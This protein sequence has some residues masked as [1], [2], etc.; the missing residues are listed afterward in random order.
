MQRLRLQPSDSSYGIPKQHHI[1]HIIHA[2]SINKGG[3]RVEHVPSDS[4]KRNPTIIDD[5]PTPVLC[6]HNANDNGDNSSSM[7]ALAAVL[8]GSNPPPPPK[9]L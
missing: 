9:H 3:L 5:L 4:E 6:P 2:I 8:D 1:I 7:A